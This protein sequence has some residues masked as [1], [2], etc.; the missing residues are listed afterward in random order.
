MGKTRRV[1]R[2]RIS[3]DILA[4]GRKFM[5]VSCPVCGAERSTSS[6]TYVECGGCRRRLRLP[7][8]RNKAVRKAVDFLCAGF[9]QRGVGARSGGVSDL[10]G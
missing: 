5:L 3:A 8:Y 10:W 6:K 7:G 9:H 1:S 4:V 2:D